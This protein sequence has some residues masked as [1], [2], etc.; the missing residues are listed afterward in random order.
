MSPRPWQVR[1]RRTPVGPGGIAG[2][3]AS[4]DLL[5]AARLFVA[6]VGHWQTIGV[7][8]GIL[9]SLDA[10]TTTGA[11]E[12][13]AWVAHARSRRTDE[14]A[15]ARVGAGLS[16]NSG[17]LVF[18]PRAWREWPHRVSDASPICGGTRLGKLDLDSIV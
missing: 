3:C 12:S 4:G 15:P 5:C 16:A 1:R 9:E 8:R 13:A 17:E 18:C 6:A 14:R 11:V 2:L 7:A 10:T